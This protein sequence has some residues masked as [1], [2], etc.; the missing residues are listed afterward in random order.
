MG[1]VLTSSSTLATAV[2]YSLAPLAWSA[3]SAGF[4]W[5]VSNDGSSWS[6]LNVSSITYATPGSINWDMGVI[7]FTYLSLN[8]TGPTSGGLQLAVTAHSTLTP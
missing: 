4:D 8:V 5:E 2:T 6:R 7:P 3:G 1:T